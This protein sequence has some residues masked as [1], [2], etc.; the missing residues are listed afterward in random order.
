MSYCRFGSGDVYAYE[1]SGGGIQFY[2]TRE[3]LDRL[4]NTHVEAYQYIKELR[5]VHGL[6]VPSYAIEQLRDEAIEEA[7]QAADFLWDVGA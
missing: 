7:K 6:S 4:C 1:C 3:N 2:T 5:D